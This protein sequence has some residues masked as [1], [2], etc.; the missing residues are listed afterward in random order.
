MPRKRHCHPF[1]S[2]CGGKH[3][4]S[5]DNTVDILPD[6]EDPKQTLINH[7]N[8]CIRHLEEGQREITTFHIG[9]TYIPDKEG[10]CRPGNP[11]KLSVKGIG[12][13]WHT[14][15]YKKD[16]IVVLTVFSRDNLPARRNAFPEG[17][18]NLPARRNAS[19][20]GYASSLV[21]QLREHFKEVDP[22]LEN[23]D[24]TAG[25]RCARNHSRYVI[26]LAYNSRLHTW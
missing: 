6:N 8:D 17:H 18:D 19:P 1:Q 15:K 26:F 25:V 10:V 14:R 23:Q 5:C 20:E 12:D 9:R 16:G 21:K 13:H 11:E 24:L 7:I 22:R 4:Y 2:L 3:G